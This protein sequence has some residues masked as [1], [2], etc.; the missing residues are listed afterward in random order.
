MDGSL[1]D[2]GQMDAAGDAV[3]VECGVLRVRAAAIRQFLRS[4]FWL[5][6]SRG[7]SCAEMGSCNLL[8]KVSKI[9]QFARAFGYMIVLQSRWACAVGRIPLMLI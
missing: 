5:C 8:R 2:Y 4:P 7:F 6:R 1:N 3:R 9:D